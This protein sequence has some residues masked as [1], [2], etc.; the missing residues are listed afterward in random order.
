M[1]AEL[2]ITFYVGVNPEDRNQFMQL[3]NEINESA[4]YRMTI[5]G[6]YDNPRGYHTYSIRGSWSSYKKFLDG[7]SFIKSVE[8]FEDF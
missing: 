7:P 5:T 2:K 1:T 4:L 8:H 6:Q 3:F